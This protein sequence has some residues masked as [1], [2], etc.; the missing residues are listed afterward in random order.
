VRRSRPAVYLYKASFMLITP[1]NR[2]D[3]PGLVRLVNTAYRG[4]GAEKGWTNESHLIRGPRTDADSLAELMDE[5]DSAILKY[6]DSEGKLVGC[7]YLQKQGA[8]LYLGLLSVDPTLQGAGVGKSLLDTSAEYGRKNKCTCIH[9]T[10]I[11]V[12]DEL[13]AWYERHGYKRTGEIEPFHIGERFGIQ[14]QPLELA[15]LERDLA[16]QAPTG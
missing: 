14:K 10:V 8:K 15:V 16:E 6:I 12:R 11:S 5:P 4:E 9:I 3:I 13:I 1:A 7:V 2:S